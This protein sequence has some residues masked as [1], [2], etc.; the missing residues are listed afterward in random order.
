MRGET[1]I[2]TLHDPGHLDIVILQERHAMTEVPAK[3]SKEIGRPRRDAGF[4]MYLSCTHIGAHTYGQN[5][6][7]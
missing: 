1:Q 2:G 6:Q 3:V 4:E 5:E 7:V